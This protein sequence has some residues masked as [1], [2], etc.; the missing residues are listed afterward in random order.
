[1]SSKMQKV[2]LQPISVI[3]RY[4]QEKALLDIW[5]YDRADV[6]IRGNILGFDEYMNLVLDHAIEFGKKSE[7]YLGIILF[8]SRQNNAQR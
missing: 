3:F 2:M 5:L 8:H 7:H 1:M 6:K 4:L